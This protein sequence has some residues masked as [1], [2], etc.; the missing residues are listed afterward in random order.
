MNLD[1]HPYGSAYG[2]LLDYLT[3]AT[4]SVRLL[5]GQVNS[6]DIDRLIRTRVYQSLLDGVGHLAGTDQQRLVNGLV[7][8]E[9]RQRVDALETAVNAFSAELKRWPENTAVAV[10]DT[11]V[12]IKHPVKLENVDFAELLGTEREVRVVVPVVVVDEL[13]RLKES[14]VPDIRWRAGYSLAVI[15]RLLDEA[16]PLSPYG[17]D[18]LTDEPGHVRLSDEDDEIVDRALAVPAMAAGLTTLVTYDTGMAMRAK[19]LGLPFRKLRTEVPP[20][21][22]TLVSYAARVWSCSC[23]CRVSSGVR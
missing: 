10:L 17:V 18:V 14:K 19:M 21:S 6:R 15:D 8:L 22:W 1:T 2:R 11:S 20:L 12:L 5:S 23:R 13:D 3:W 7:A 16:G 4:D 9:V